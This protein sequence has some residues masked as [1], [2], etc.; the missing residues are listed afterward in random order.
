M[1]DSADQP[2]PTALIT[3][4]GTGGGT[5]NGAARARRRPHDGID[6]PVH[7]AGGALGARRVEARDLDRSQQMDATSGLA[8]VRVAQA[9]L[10]WRGRSAPATIAPISSIA[11][12]RVH[13]GVDPSP[14]AHDVAQGVAF[15]VGLPQNVNVDTTVTEPV[16]QAAPW[17]LHRGS[18]DGRNA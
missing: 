7:D 13:A 3:G 1:T 4:G 15:C 9:A 5:G 12:E 8:S 16:A 14:V 18:I 2:R 10:P 17:E 11:G 6:V